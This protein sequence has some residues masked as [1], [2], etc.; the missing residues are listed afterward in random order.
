MTNKE[1]HLRRLELMR[2]D[3]KRELDDAG[4]RGN[5]PEM[6]RL[7]DQYASISKQIEAAL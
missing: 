7:A 3:V 1:H 5:F 2:L 6:E 4:Y